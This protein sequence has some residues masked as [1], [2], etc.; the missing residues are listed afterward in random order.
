[1]L[2][3][4]LL[5]V[6]NTQ[7]DSAIAIVTQGPNEPHVVNSWNSYIQIDGEDKLLI[8]VGDMIQT[9]KNIEANNNIKLTISNREVMGK[10]YKGTGFL[11]TG[12]AAFI[13]E[14]PEFDIVK[15]KFPWARAA[16]TI[17]V[18]STEQTL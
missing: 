10:R 1:M 11:V 7:P 9:Q 15:S 6:I 16:L 18:A 4:K 5:E 12:T 13:T 8:P 3:V 17:T 2:D 14:G